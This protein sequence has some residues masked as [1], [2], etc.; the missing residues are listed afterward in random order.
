LGTLNILPHGGFTATCG[1]IQITFGLIQ[2]DPLCERRM[3]AE[4]VLEWFRVLDSCDGSA[5]PAVTRF[6]QVLRS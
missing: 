1:G 6:D 2:M 4:D 3:P 5:D